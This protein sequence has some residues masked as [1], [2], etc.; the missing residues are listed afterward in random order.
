MVPGI[1]ML[2]QLFIICTHLNGFKYSYQ[3]RMI[4]FS[5]YIVVRKRYTVK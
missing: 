2:Y 1:V 3:I 5:T 4:L